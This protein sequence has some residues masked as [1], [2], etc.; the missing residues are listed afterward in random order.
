[1]SQFDKYAKGYTAAVKS[2]TKAEVLHRENLDRLDEALKAKQ[3][4]QVTHLRRDAAKTEADLVA[5]LDAASDA[6]REYWTARRDAL[7]PELDS[8]ALV[9]AEYNALAKLAGD[10]NAHPAASYLQQKAIDGR[11]A[12]NLLEQ[13][14]LATDGV[15][16]EP[17]DSAVLEDYRG[18]WRA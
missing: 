18:S 13:D 17:V 11:S 16:Q 15:P 1:M 5:A 9:I 6:H 3:A 7:K 14:V 12:A 8:A 10:H 2:L 4:H